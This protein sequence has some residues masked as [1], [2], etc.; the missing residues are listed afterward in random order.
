MLLKAVKLSIVLTFVRA[1]QPE[2]LQWYK[3]G[4]SSA[5]ELALNLDAIYLVEHW[6][7]KDQ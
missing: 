7:L 6:D 5:A 4:N 1:Y 2:K 3:T